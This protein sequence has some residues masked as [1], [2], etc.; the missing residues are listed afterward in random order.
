M[1]IDELDTPV[2]VID[3][4]ALRDNLT[5]YQ[6]YYDEHGILLRPHIKTHKTLSIASMQLA[7]GAIGLTCQK[8]GSDGVRWSQD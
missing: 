6:S 5:R 4:D 3:I 1:H 8:V 2:L 7:Q